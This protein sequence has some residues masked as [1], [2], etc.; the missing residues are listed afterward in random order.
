M[1]L[2]LMLFAYEVANEHNVAFS[3]LMNNS[4]A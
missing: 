3:V 4:T 2:L 1:G